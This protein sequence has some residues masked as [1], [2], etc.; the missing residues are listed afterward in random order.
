MPRSSYTQRELLDEFHTAD[1]RVRSLFLNSAIERRHL[2]L[3]PRGGDGMRTVET[4]GELLRKHHVSGVEL[5]MRPVDDCLRSIGGSRS[6]VWYLCCVSSTG[7]LTPGFSSLLIKELGLS[8]SCSRIDVV[9]MG[10]NTGLNV[11]TAI[12]SWASGHPDELALMV[13]IEVCSAAYVFDGTTRTTVVNSLFGDGV[14][15]AFVVA[16]TSGETTGRSAGAS[17][18]RGP[19]LL[20]FASRLVPEAIDAMRYHWDDGHG[21]FSFFPDIEV[22][23]VVGAH[24]ERAVDALLDRA[25]ERPPGHAAMGRGRAHRTRR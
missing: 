3:P 13:C 20:R 24:V 5:G 9:G 21:K 6:D 12:A 10:C 17:A 14:P 25:R 19:T 4:Q 1:P 18:W 2:T 15:P 7:F 8:D 22:P 11:L 23:Y 16:D